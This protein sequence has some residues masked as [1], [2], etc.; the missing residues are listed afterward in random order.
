MCFLIRE[1]QDIKR[2][3]LEYKQI[4]LEISLSKEVQKNLG[5]GV[6]RID[7]SESL[8]RSLGIRLNV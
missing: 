6:Y 4:K 3:I 8:C 2:F 1:I 7:E 5:D